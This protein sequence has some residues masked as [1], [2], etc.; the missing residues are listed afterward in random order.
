MFQQ[1]NMLGHGVIAGDSQHP[2]AHAPASRIGE[3]LGQNYLGI[4]D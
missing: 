1:H 2:L 4:R 3:V